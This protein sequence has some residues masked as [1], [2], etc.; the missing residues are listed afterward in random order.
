MCDGKRLRVTV[1]PCVQHL[2]APCGPSGWVGVGGV[3]EVGGT[4][5]RHNSPTPPPPL[6]KGKDDG[7]SEQ[8]TQPPVSPPPHRPPPAPAA[9]V[10]DTGAGSRRSPDESLS[11][12][13][14]THQRSQE[15]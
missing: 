13:A 3:K 4:L 1:I 2:Y 5:T 7:P 10:T 9:E 11:R 8:Q 15:S 14:V 12:T 6:L